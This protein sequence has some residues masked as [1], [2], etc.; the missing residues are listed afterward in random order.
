MSLQLDD[1]RLAT[2]PS[3]VPPADA[4]HS[5]PPV[6]FIQ[7][8]T[9]PCEL[10]RRDQRPLPARVAVDI[11]LGDLN[12]LVTSDQLHVAQGAAEAP[13]SRRTRERL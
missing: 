6:A 2:A 3:P 13:A 9:Q 10:E 4:W 5:F 12:R 7:A 1:F 8:N 11:A